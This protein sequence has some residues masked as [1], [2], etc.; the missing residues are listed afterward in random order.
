ML[1]ALVIHKTGDQEPG[2]GFFELAKDLGKDTS[3]MLTC[4]VT[5]VKKVHDY[6][7]RPE[8]PGDKTK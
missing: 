4:W 2:P 3:D 7:N 1:S 5:E 6:W 8:K